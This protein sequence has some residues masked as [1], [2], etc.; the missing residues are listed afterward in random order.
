MMR[1][2]E[3]IAESEISLETTD[4]FKRG[5]M[6]GRRKTLLAVSGLLVV[7][8][9]VVAVVGASERADGSAPS[10]SLLVYTV[11]SN[12]DTPNDCDICMPD[13]KGE[14]GNGCGE[15]THS[16]ACVD[17]TTTLPAGCKPTCQRS[18]SFGSCISGIGANKAS[19]TA[20]DEEAGGVLSCFEQLLS[21]L[22]L[23]T[24]G[25]LLN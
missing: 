4:D 20:L 16:C 14:L 19:D 24:L 21:G 23:A 22:Y 11:C 18:S 6:D 13:S 9:F 2:G 5:F 17:G 12:N 10:R 7:T 3:I 1:N 25:Q 15:M 8:A